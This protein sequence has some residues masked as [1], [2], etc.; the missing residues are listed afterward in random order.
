MDRR[1]FQFATRRVRCKKNKSFSLF[2]YTVQNIRCKENYQC[3]ADL[4][5]DWFGFNKTSETVL[6]I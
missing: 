6:L 4:L 3:M 1:P 2:F 5:P